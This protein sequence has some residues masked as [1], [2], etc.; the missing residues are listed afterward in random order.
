M[1]G[2]LWGEAAD[3]RLP[4]PRSPAARSHTAGR[5]VGSGFLRQAAPSLWESRCP[6]PDSSSEAGQLGPA[7]G[8]STGDR[9][10]RFLPSHRPET[11]GESEAETLLE[12]LRPITPIP[13]TG[14]PH[15]DALHEPGSLAGGV[16]G[17]RGG[18]LHAS[19][20]RLYL[21]LK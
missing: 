3:S 8:G 2:R 14:G 1:W 4:G 19:P 21:S 16:R 11:G 12:S 20:W 5:P 15:R 13:G 18:H 6:E 7:H 17:T 9:V 10:P